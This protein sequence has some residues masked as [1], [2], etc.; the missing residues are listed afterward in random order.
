MRP[1]KDKSCHDTLEL[2][3]VIATLLKGFQQEFTTQ[4]LHNL[5]LMC[6]T[7]A[8]MIPKIIRWL[9]EDFSPLR[10]PR[11]NYKQQERI[12]PHRI[13]MASAAMIYFG[14]DPRKFVRWL[15]GKYAGHHWD[16]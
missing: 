2:Y 5:R 4:E 15:G 14:L 11:Y 7:F 10:K 6:K 9:K 3:C 16:V 12:D 1:S 8:S 13:K